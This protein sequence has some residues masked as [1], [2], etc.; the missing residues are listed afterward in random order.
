MSSDHLQ[1]KAR[2]AGFVCR[3][4]KL[5]ADSFVG[6][7][8]YCS[9]R[10]DNSSLDS[11][12]RVLEDYWGI[13]IRKQSLD[14]RFN[15][16]CLDFVKSILQEMLEEQL[17]SSCL[18]KDDFWKNFPQIRVKDSTKFKVPDNMKKQFKGN[19]GSPAGICIQY[20]YDL[21]KGKIL[22]LSVGSGGC[23]DRTDAVKTK[24]QPRK[25]ELVIRD[26]GYYSLDVF[27][28]FSTNK[29]FFLSR[30]SSQTCVFE[31]RGEKWK[32]VDFKKI[33]NKMLE[34][35]I[36]QMEMKVNLGVDY[37][38]PV[39]MILSLVDN[40]VY[41]KRIREREKENR[42]RGQK[43]SEETRIRYRFS[44]YITNADEK[45]LPITLVF[46]A[47]RLRWQ[48]ELIFK[49][50]KSIYK[51]HI[52]RKMKQNRYL[53]MLYAK[54]LLIV[55]NLQ[56]TGSLQESIQKTDKHGKTQFLSTRK[57]L[58]TL[59]IYFYDVYTALVSNGSRKRNIL[60]YLQNK[61]ASNHWLEK[62]KNKQYT[63]EIIDLRV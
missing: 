14:E 39:R 1:V 58:Y 22:D 21:V 47:Y 3:G 46:S 49:C 25:G 54:L 41:E 30:L 59:R 45:S 34:G 52:G 17:R 61:I 15:E 7:L 44:I 11:M 57:V 60:L 20:E 48:I 40:Q 12:C 4:K 37:K 56:I 10:E 2:E 51:V 38:L 28:T 33:Y 27:K 35:N 18:Y 9:S 53:C 26:L 8:L 6:M 32:E 50:W 42:K 55:I 24:D 43:M 36:G 23:C 19:G 63:D 5:T 16:A 29:V 31:Q 13:N 62:K